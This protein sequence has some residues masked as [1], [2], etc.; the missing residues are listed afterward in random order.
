[1][2][3]AFQ[4]KSLH[5]VLRLEEEWYV[6]EIRDGSE[7]DEVFGYLRLRREGEIIK[8]FFKRQHDDS[9]ES[10]NTIEAK[11]L[12]YLRMGAKAA[13]EAIAGAAERQKE[14]P[15]CCICFE[16]LDVQDDFAELRCR[17]MYHKS[18][19]RSWFTRNGS[20]PMRCEQP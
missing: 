7:A 6:A 4:E 3:L 17:H 19:I 15:M 18:C 11:P 1:M 14:Q 12:P 20:C 13:A 8:S 2:Q 10:S 9:W 16:A 5:G